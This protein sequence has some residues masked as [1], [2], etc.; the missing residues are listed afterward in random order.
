LGQEIPTFAPIS[1]IESP[2]CAKTR[3]FSSDTLQSGFRRGIVSRGMINPASFSRRS[4][5]LTELGFIPTSGAT[6][7]GQSQLLRSEITST[8]IQATFSPAQG[9][10]SLSDKLQRCSSITLESLKSRCP[11]SM[12]LRVV[13]RRTFKCLLPE[14]R[15]HGV[16][17][18]R[19]YFQDSPRNPACK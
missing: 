7:L 4:R 12:R 14:Q 10:Q 15:L 16:C 1:G 8:L 13:L 2:D 5:S 9:F 3:T 18:L 17:S 11:Q 6:A 19:R